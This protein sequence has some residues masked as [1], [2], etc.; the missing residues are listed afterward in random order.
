LCALHLPTV[1]EERRN[2]F[3]SQR[4]RLSQIT[5][6]HVRVCVRVKRVSE[7]FNIKLELFRVTDQVARFQLALVGENQIVH[8]PKFPLRS[9]SEQRL[10][11]LF[12]FRVKRQRRVF[13]DQ[14]DFV[15]ISAHELPAR[16]MMRARRTGIPYQRIR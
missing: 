9:G 2:S 5:L 4:A 8:L 11:R 3:D 10:V 6:N 13:E 14:T 12:R 7:I 15:G 1:D 16:L